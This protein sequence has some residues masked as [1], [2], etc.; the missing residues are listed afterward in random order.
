[1]ACQQY[2]ERRLELV[3]LP[4]AFG[5]PEPREPLNSESFAASRASSWRIVAYCPESPLPRKPAIRRDR[6]DDF[7]AR[8]DVL[9][10]I[11]PEQAMAS[12]S[13]CGAMMT[14]CSLPVVDQRSAR[15]R[16]SL[17]AARNPQ[18]HESSTREDS[19]RR[20]ALSHGLK[21]IEF[22]STELPILRSSAIGPATRSA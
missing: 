19:R 18:C 2:A 4:G 15:L 11:V 12:S 21:D 7:V 9:E 3:C 8:F 6:D 1:M 22:R 5:Q 17:P 16:V 13:G 20:A 10:A 14:T